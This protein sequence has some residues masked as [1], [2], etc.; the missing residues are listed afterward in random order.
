MTKPCAAPCCACGRTRMLRRAKLVG[1]GRGVN[2]A[3]RSTTTFLRE[4]PRLYNA[5]RP[6]GARRPA[7]ASTGRG[8]AA[9]FCSSRASWIG[10]ARRQPLRH[11]RGAGAG[12]ARAKPQGRSAYLL[13]QLH[14]C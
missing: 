3:P 1:D 12:D 4:L 7:G 14:L 6:P 13:E 10:G 5:A 9:G 11:R 2:N 8:R